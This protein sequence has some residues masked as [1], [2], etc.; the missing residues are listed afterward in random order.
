[1]HWADLQ[2]SFSEGFLFDDPHRELHSESLANVLSQELF[3]IQIQQISMH[4]DP[5]GAEPELVINGS[6]RID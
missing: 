3:F 4:L 5:R 6:V 1:M 2:R